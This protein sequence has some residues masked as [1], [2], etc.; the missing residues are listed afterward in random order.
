[1]ADVPVAVFFSATDE[2]PETILTALAKA[3]AKPYRLVFP[4]Y[5]H[6]DSWIVERLEAYATAFGDEYLRDANRLRSGQS[7]SNEL[8]EFI[9][10]ADVFQLFWSENAAASQNVEKEWKCALSE[11][12]VRADPFFIRPVFWTA[13]PAPIP[14]ELEALHFSRLPLENS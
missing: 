5:S 11:R 7:W 12:K 2:A 10:R 13:K 1:L 4:S 6:K 3:N 9:H 8:E 14:P